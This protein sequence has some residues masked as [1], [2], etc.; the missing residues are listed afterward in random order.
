ME[1]RARDDFKSPWAALFRKILLG[2]P[3]L[4][5]LPCNNIQY[6]ETLATNAFIVVASSLVRE[7]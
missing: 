3:I 7:P 5:S 6:V 4:L 1:G 2:T